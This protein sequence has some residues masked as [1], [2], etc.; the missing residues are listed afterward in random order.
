[1]KYFFLEIMKPKKSALARKLKSAKKKKEIESAVLGT[2]KQFLGTPLESN[3]LDFISQ[4][5]KQILN[6]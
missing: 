1:M 4:H 6:Q 3:T 5:I 2:L